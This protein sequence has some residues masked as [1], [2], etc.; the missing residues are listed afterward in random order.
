MLT[1]CCGASAAAAAATIHPVSSVHSAI[2]EKARRENRGKCLPAK[3]R[4]T[5]GHKP[6]ALAKQV[7]RERIE[8][9]FPL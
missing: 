1:L 3:R 9:S 7:D 6:V 2:A 8:T 5:G 4:G